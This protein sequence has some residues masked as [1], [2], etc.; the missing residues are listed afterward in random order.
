[1]TTSA[2]SDRVVVDLGGRR[3]AGMALAERFAQPIP[4]VE[5]FRELAA[6]IRQKSAILALNPERLDKKPPIYTA[7][8][9]DL[10]MLRRCHTEFQD[11]VRSAVRCSITAV[12]PDQDRAWEEAWQMLAT[13]IPHTADVHPLHL[14]YTRAAKPIPELLTELQTEMHEGVERTLR[15]LADWLQLLAESE[16]VGLVEWSDVDVC[17]YSYFRHEFTTTVTPGKKRSETTLDE[18][19]PFGER[20]TYRI[21]RDRTVATAQVLERHVHHI[22]DARVHKIADYLHPVPSHVA[23]FLNSVPASLE[24]HLSIVE[25]IITMEERHRRL[26]AEG[27]RTETEILSVY[28]GSPGVL[29]GPFNLIGWSRDDLTQGGVFSSKQKVSQRKPRSI[30]G[31]LKRASGHLFNA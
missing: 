16:L 5:F 23:A 7:Y 11:C 9:H 6:S 12:A 15:P 27:T 22:V 4:N 2:E 18:T 13:Q 3:F 20:T 30:S 8:A 31:H 17:C 14:P 1:M 24:P 29:L 28:K 21:L 26:I 10:E 19:K 25:G